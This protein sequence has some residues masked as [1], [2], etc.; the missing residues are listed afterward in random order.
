MNSSSPSTDSRSALSAALEELRR[1]RAEIEELRRERTEPIAVI[2]MAC[3]FPGGSDTPER[4]WQ[5][6]GRGLSAITEVPA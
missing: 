4:F 1:R 3:R 5:L 6:L 2:G